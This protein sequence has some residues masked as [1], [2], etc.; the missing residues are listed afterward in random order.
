LAHGDA[1][2]PVHEI[3]TMMA[4]RGKSLTATEELIESILDYQFGDGETFGVLA[5]MFPHVNT[6]NVHHVDHIVPRARLSKGPLHKAG[7]DDGK[8]DEILAL[9]DGLPNLELL[10]GPEN[11]AK[12]AKMPLAWARDVYTSPEVYSAYLDRNALPE[13]ID[14][15]ADF[16][17]FYDSRRAQ[18][19]ER[20]R[21]AF[22]L[23]ASSAQETR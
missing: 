17:E 21:R 16:L 4:G 23:A 11:V 9:R 10:E 22:G 14:D 7:V 15:P 20:I 5:I 19:R 2:F 18:M 3:D 1:G 6:R 8:V 12:N 13:L